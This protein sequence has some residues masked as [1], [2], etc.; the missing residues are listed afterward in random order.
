MANV[1]LYCERVGTEIWAEPINALTNIAFFIAAWSIWYLSRRSSM[2]SP[3][4]WLLIATA[5][6][7]GTGSFVFHTVATSWA[8]WLDVIPILVFQLLFLWLYSRRII[9]FSQPISGLLLAIFLGA[10]LF[11]R[12]FPEILNGSLTYAPAI[13]T[14]LALGVYHAT[15]TPIGRFDLLIAAGVFVASLFFRT[16]DHATC[17]AFPI[18]THFMWHILNGA[19]VFLTAHALVRRPVR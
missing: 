10:A 15:R 17:A 4:I 18:G 8:R 9:A 6:A 16:V 19:V 14:V 12:Q 7:I 2:L 11:S 1:D 13:L 5:I 3:S